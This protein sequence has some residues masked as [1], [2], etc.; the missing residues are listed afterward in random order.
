MRRSA[1]H[2]L[3]RAEQAAD[4]LFLAGALGFITPRQ[5]AVLIAVSEIEGGNL[6]YVVERTGID[7]ST[8]SEMVGRMAR[9]GLLQKRRSRRDTRSF[10]LRLTEEGRQLLD[11]ATPVARNIDAALLRSLPPDR[12]EPF[13]Q[14][15]QAIVKGLEGQM[16]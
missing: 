10:V 6:N 2:L 16:V 15:L 12:R 9:M 5:L 13:L 7:R 14:A 8:T 11:S 4:Q 1:L 3:H